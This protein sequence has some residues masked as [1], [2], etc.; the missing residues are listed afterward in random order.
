MKP[1]A[2]KRLL[3]N[4]PAAVGF[5]AIASG[6][7]LGALLFQFRLRVGQYDP[8]AVSFFYRLFIFEDYP[9]SYL[10]I[11][12]VAIAAVPDYQ[13]AAAG[14]ARVI[15]NYP[16]AASMIA[17]VAFAAGS[18]WIYHAHPLS[19]DEAAPYMQSKASA[20]G[21]L[22]GQYPA[23]LLDWLVP[24]SMQNSFIVVSPGTGQ[25]A[26]AHWPGFAL[27]LTPFMAAGVPCWFRKIAGH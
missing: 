22:L 9:A 19:A 2:A 20:H 27:L 24:R 3:W 16:L 1:G 12:A 5:A 8:E 17:T 11:A 7:T 13:R 14:L 10:F 18:L 15:G 21:A 25:I 26:S 23:P 4:A 6:I